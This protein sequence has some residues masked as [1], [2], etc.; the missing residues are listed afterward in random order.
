MKIFFRITGIPPLANSLNNIIWINTLRHIHSPV[1]DNYVHGLLHRLKNSW[2]ICQYISNRM[3]KYPVYRIQYIL[4]LCCRKYS[5]YGIDWA[6]LLWYVEF[7]NTSGRY[8]KRDGCKY[9]MDQRNDRKTLHRRC[10][11]IWDR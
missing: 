11:E 7:K 1:A 9:M 8:Y 6:W 5:S 10:T 2:K 4:C 3:S